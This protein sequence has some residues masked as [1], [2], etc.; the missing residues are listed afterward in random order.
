M[1]IEPGV[2]IEFELDRGA[3]ILGQMNA[4]GT[5]DK[6]IIFRSSKGQIWSGL[7]FENAGKVKAM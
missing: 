6:P 2:V 5:A 4:I 1:T 3:Y 7:V